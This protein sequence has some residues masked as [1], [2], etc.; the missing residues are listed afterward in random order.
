MDVDCSWERLASQ[1]EFVSRFAEI[2]YSD[3]FIPLIAYI[4]DRLN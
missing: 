1:D 3:E 4:F 2:S